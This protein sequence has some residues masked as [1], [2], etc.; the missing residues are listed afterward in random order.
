MFA[1]CVTLIPVKMTNTKFLNIGK[2]IIILNYYQYILKL[3]SILQ[4]KHLQKHLHYFRN[5]VCSINAL[6]V[7]YQVL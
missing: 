5:Y 1:V 3:P 7:H 6:N 2:L 4:Q